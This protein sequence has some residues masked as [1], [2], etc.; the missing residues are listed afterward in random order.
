MNNLIIN[1]PIVNIQY[2]T[3]KVRV[4]IEF[5]PHSWRGVLNTTL[6]DKVSQWL[7]TGRWFSLGIPVSSTNKT[8]RHDITE[9]LLRVAPTQKTNN[10][11]TQNPLIKGGWTQVLSIDKHFLIDYWHPLWY[12]CL[13]R[14]RG[15][16]D[17][18]MMAL[19][20]IKPNQ[21]W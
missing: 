15:K 9:I 11:A 16:K 13:S 14:G 8:D 20:T 7:V 6:C 4:C 12:S 3:D 5:E 1:L 2:S 18:I 21:T 19:S 10:W 17:R